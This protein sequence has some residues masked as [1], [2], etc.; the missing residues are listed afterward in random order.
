[1]RYTRILRKVIGERLFFN[2]GYYYL[3]CQP[4]FR[5]S[6][7]Q[8]RQLENTF[9]G[10]RCFIIGNGPSLARMD[11][12]PLKN[13]ITFGSNRIYL[14][15]PKL[16]FQTTF[17]VAVNKLVIEQCASEIQ[18]KVTGTKFISYDAR[19]WLPPG[20]KLIYLYSRDGPCFYDRAQQGIWQGGTVTFVAIQL[21][22]TLGFNQV[23]LLGVDHH[24]H[25]QSNPHEIVIGNGEDPNHFDRGYFGQG[26]RWQAP[27]LLLS[28]QAYHLAKKHFEAD[29]RQILDATLGGKL[30]VFPKIDYYSL[31]NQ[32]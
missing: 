14:L 27:D 31:F 30:D 4:S 22:Y 18:H 3:A 9:T 19:R 16:G 29:G 32:K 7:T 24:Y 11:L 12:A 15:F 21:A 25:T 28:E 17:Y 20:D 5:Q 23:I 2:L 26:F 13:E 10:Q 6:I 1:M 8:L